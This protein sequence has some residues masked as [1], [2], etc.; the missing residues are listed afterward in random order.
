MDPIKDA[1]EKVRLDIDS[2]NTELAEISKSIVETR[3]QM[4][5]L[6]GVIQKL[7]EKVEN[8]VKKQEKHEKQEKTIVLTHIPTYNPQ[9]PTTPTHNPTLPQE[10]GGLKAQNLGSS[11][12][13]EGVPTDRQTDKQTFQHIL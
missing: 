6:C 1:F 5:E 8:I 11:T 10:I 2:L 12:G 7:F 13:N 3:S 9:N 4:S